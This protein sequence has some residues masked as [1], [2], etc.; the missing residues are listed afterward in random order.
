MTKEEA[1]TV[2]RELGLGPVLDAHPSEMSKYYVTNDFTEYGD[3]LANFR[4]TFAPLRE[5]DL[6]SELE[7][8]KKKGYVPDPEDAPE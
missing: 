5:G 2:L 4:E 6:R 7:E 8:L 3:P 1:E